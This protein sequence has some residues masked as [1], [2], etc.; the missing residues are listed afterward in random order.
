MDLNFEILNLNFHGSRYHRY[1]LEYFYKIM[2]DWIGEKYMSDEY[3]Q[4][5]K[6]LKLDLSFNINKFIMMLNRN[7]NLVIRFANIISFQ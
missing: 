4:I 2:D 3:Y 1:F 6:I 7:N 5:F